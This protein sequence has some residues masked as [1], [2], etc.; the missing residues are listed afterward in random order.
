MAQRVGRQAGKHGVVAVH[1]QR[2]DRHSA[3]TAGCDAAG[4]PHRL[5]ASTPARY[6]SATKRL[7]VTAAA[8]DLQCLRAD[9][10]CNLTVL[11]HRQQHPLGTAHAGSLNELDKIAGQRRTRSALKLGKP[12]R[13]GLGDEST[14]PHIANGRWLADGSHG[15]GPHCRVVLLN[16]PDLARRQAAG[17]AQVGH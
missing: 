5:C 16:L 11:L 4:G 8:I 12:Q 17:Q 14:M 3:H 6:Q 7:Q 13:M 9:L 1:A 2:T 15:L 10:V